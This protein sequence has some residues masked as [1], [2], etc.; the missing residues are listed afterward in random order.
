MIP[1]GGQEGG[2]GRGWLAAFTRARDGR[3]QERK[4][5]P[6]FGIQQAVQPLTMLHRLPTPHSKFTPLLFSFFAKRIESSLFTI[7]VG[8]RGRG[9]RKEKGRMHK[10]AFGSLLLLIFISFF[11]HS[12]LKF[13]FLQHGFLCYT[14]FLV[15]SN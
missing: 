13:F 11:I 9:G 7:V 6:P 3:P 15:Q 5:T 10:M 12:F 2:G 4:K 14:F 1:L 8:G